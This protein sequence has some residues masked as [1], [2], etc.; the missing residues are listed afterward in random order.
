MGR[1]SKTF[2]LLLMLIITISCLTLQTVKPVEAQ[3]PSATPYPTLMAPEFTVEVTNTSY[4]EPI[5]YTYDPTTGQMIANTSYYSGYVDSLNVTISIKNQPIVQTT[6]S[7]YRSGFKYFV[8]FNGISLTDGGFVPSNG[9][10]TTLSMQFSN[11]YFSIAGKK[12]YPDYSSG[13]TYATNPFYPI[14]T[15]TRNE[16]VSV[17][18]LLFVGEFVILSLGIFYPEGN[19]SDWNYVTL[20]MASGET[21]SVINKPTTTP[22]ITPTSNPSVQEVTPTLTTNIPRDPPHLDLIYYLIPVGV[23]AVVVM[24]SV[25]LYRRH[26]KTAKLKQ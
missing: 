23:L 19:F 22:T 18:V 15:V 20:P 7:D 24:L 21:G 16:L 25:L 5:T 2:A 17:Q 26:R 3:S 14:I 9:S 10:L 4:Y 12:N 8:R 13:L 6:Y 11:P 1:I